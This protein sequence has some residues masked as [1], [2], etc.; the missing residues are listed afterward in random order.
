MFCNF[1]YKFTLFSLAILSIV[2]LF[3]L[4]INSIKDSEGTA[5]LITNIDFVLNEKLKV[6]NITYI[7]QGEL[8]EFKIKTNKKYDLIFVSCGADLSVWSD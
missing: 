3:N 7:T 4:N 1:F 6:S 8:T 5:N 2:I